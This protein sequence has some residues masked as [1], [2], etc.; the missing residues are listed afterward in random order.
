MR[1]VTEETYLK[2][3]RKLMDRIKDMERKQDQLI[4]LVNVISEK[5]GVIHKGLIPSSIVEVEY[6][7]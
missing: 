6:N 3:T 1:Y 5:N 7:D 2:V 4:E